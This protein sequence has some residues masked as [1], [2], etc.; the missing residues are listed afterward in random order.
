MTDH[1]IEELLGAYALDAVTDIERRQVE[2]ALDLDPR[3][4]AEAD[5]L[6]AV[7]LVLAGDL[8]P[9]EPAPD[10]LWATIEAEISP[11]AVGPIH[12]RRPIRRR[13]AAAA[14]AAAVA[15]VAVLAVTVFLQRTEISDLREDP[16]ASAVEETADRAGA[17][18]MTLSGDTTVDVVL[19]PDGV[20]Y[21]LGDELPALDA[22]ST[23]QLWAIVDDRV[24]S[25]G[26]LGAEPAVSPFRVDGPVAGFA[27]TVEQAGGVVSSEQDPI[28]V[29]LLEG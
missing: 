1:E 5:E 26:V 23:Y 18:T 4:R 15:I 6:V 21:V 16:L 20:G 12:R 7:S 11:P 28:A 25:A 29:G 2:R 9:D 3:L 17:I 24:I 27:L 19:G 10:H 14:G 22:D 8:A 13:L